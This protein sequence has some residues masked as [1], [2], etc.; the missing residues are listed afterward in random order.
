MEK[1]NFKIATD[2]E[3]EVALSAQYRLNLPIVVNENK[4][5]QCSGLLRTHLHMTSLEVW[6]YCNGILE[7]SLTRGFLQ[8]TLQRILRMT[9]HASLIR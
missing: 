2:E 1:S 5:H 4:V 6:W 8:V 7:C 3:I 9:F